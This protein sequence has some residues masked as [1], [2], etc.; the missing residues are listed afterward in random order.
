MDKVLVE[1]VCPATSKEYDFWISKKMKVKNAIEK[2]A[3]DIMQ[4]ELND[5]LFD[6]EKMV[7]LYFYE[8]RTLLNRELTMEQSGVCS[9]CR[10][11]II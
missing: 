8:H 2:I 7:V 10:L 11:M 5:K 9:G 3:A 1:I 4:Y 6:L